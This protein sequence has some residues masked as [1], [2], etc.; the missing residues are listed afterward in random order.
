VKYKQCKGEKMKCK[1][2][3]MLLILCSLLSADMLLAE[4]PRGIFRGVNH[5][6][7]VD[8]TN[9]TLQLPPG[10]NFTGYF[11]FWTLGDTLIAN[12]VPT[13]T[14]NWVSLNPSTFISTSCSAVVPVAINFV[15]PSNIGFYTATF[16]DQNGNWDDLVINLTITN[17]PD[18]DI[19]DTVFI[20]PGE[21]VIKTESIT[22]SG[23]T[24]IGCYTV[25]FPSTSAVVQYSASPTANWLT[26]NPATVTLTMNNP[27]ALIN[28]KF[29]W[30][31]S[32][33]YS[34][35]EMRSVQWFSYPRY[36]KWTLKVRELEAPSNLIYNELI[37]TLT[38]VAPEIPFQNYVISRKPKFTTGAQWQLVEADSGGIRGVEETEW[39][40][41]TN[42][43]YYYKIGAVYV[44]GD[45]LYS[46][47]V[48]VARGYF[49]RRIQNDIVEPYNVY[50]SNYR[51]I[52]NQRQYMWPSNWWLRF[53]YQN[54]SLFDQTYF[55]DVGPSIFPDWYLASEIRGYERSY[56]YY[57]DRVNPDF[58]N[59]WKN[60]RESDRDWSGSCLGF[61]I[62]AIFDFN[63]FAPYKQRFSFFSGQ[64]PAEVAMTNSAFSDSVRR[65][66]NYFMETQSFGRATYTHQTINRTPNE[67]LQILYSDFAN[68][69]NSFYKFIDI[70]GNNKS[71]NHAVL[72]YAIEKV[73]DN[74]TYIYIY[75]SNAPSNDIKRIEINTANNTW[76]IPG[77]INTFSNHFISVRGG[78]ENL[79]NASIINKEGNEQLDKFDVFMTGSTSSVV[80]QS[81]DTLVSFNYADTSYSSMEY[82]IAYPTDGILRAPDGYELEVGEYT[83]IFSD[84]DS[85]NGNPGIYLKNDINGS[86]GFKRKSA[87][88][89]N[90]S[91]LVSFGINKMI[92][93][94][95]DNN[96]KN[97]YL[98][99]VIDNS[100]NLSN[101]NVKYFEARNFIIPMGD[102]VS[103]SKTADENILLINFGQ[104]TN[105]DLLI[106]YTDTLKSLTFK[107]D[108]AS[109]PANSGLTIKPEWENLQ[110][111]VLTIYVDIGNNGT[112]DDTLSLVNQVTGIQNDYVSY[113]SPDSYHLA[114]N[115]PNPFN[116]STKISWQLPVGSWQTLKVYDILGNEVAALVNEYQGSRKV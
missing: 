107:Y 109:I 3:F 46:D 67:V 68:Y 40:I 52:P 2:L 81:V 71:Y 92:Y 21:S 74:L 86:S 83:I 63:N 24:G 8:I 89:P 33:V 12:F 82:V 87:D 91:D 102:S 20:L 48:N 19:P 49:L 16:I 94:N 28:K 50:K 7:T 84:Y 62:A 64:I 66:I 58:V 23:L 31:N 90:E 115:Y 53:D 30:D 95:P 97:I 85:L 114:Q 47:S 42:G 32:G 6:G 103:V 112:I 65:M 34:T 76:R 15:T 38:W 22:A 39:V 88:F 1:K 55:S 43:Y 57:P 100:E 116:P 51:L 93:V 35:Y 99:Q 111:S 59:V 78:I 104:T 44:S 106:T 75:D 37:H 96:Q 113:I 79:F 36:I 56:V 14:V 105:L 108:Q 10:K 25:Y 70:K 72:P 11:Y 45:T 54:P 98:Y 80:M 60:R 61:A 69:Q 17:T 77:Y 26:F 9:Y 5:E 41:R 73:S 13:A 4:E 29:E 18:A 110:N 27:S 101:K